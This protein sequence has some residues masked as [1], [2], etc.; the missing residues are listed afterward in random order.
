MLVIWGNHQRHG[1]DYSKTFSPVMH[2]ESSRT[3]LT[4]PTIRNLNIT[5]FNITSSYLHCTPKKGMY[6]GRP[7]GYITP[8]KEGWVWQLKGLYMQAKARGTWD[9][10]LNS[11]M[12]S[13]GSAAMP[14]NLSDYAEHSWG[15]QDFTPG[16]SWVDDL[17][18]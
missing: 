18:G 16:N 2:L 4:I 1:I 8:R 13:E 6:M 14:K 12:E 5:Q 3:L 17:L 9:E 10:G 11:P 15:C 7:D